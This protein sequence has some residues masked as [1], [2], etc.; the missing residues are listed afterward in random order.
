M[1]G[2]AIDAVLLVFDAFLLDIP[3]AEVS[4][5]TFGKRLTADKVSSL[6]SD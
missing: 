2:C 4:L 5:I 6:S 1:I 3:Y